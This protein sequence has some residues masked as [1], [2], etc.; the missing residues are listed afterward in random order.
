MIANRNRM[1]SQCVIGMLVVIWSGTALAQISHVE[2]R[3]LASNIIVPQSRDRAFCI[4]RREQ[5][6]QVTEVIGL[7]DI[8]DQ[9]A[10]T[11]IEIRLKNPSRRRQEAE[12]IMP[13]PEGA[14]IRGFTFQGA[15]K[16]P[17]AQVL[18]KEEAKRIYD[19]LV[20]K[21]KDPALLEFAGYNLV[22]SSV[23]PVEAN[24]TQKV[25]L[26]YEHILPIDG[27][28]IDYILPRSEMLDYKVPWKVSVKIK[29]ARPVSTIYSPSHELKEKR[30]TSNEV[31]VEIAQ[32]SCK[33]PG[34]FRLSILMQ[35]NGVTATMLSYPNPKVGGGYFL[36]LGGLPPKLAQ[37]SQDAI[38]REIILVIDRS[39]SM[40]GEK[41]EQ[42]RE[43]ALQIIA[44]LNDGEN[45]NIVIYNNTV[46][47]FS[48]KP[49]AK[50]DKYEKAAREYIKGIRAT[51]GTNI[52]DALLE[53]LRQK[54]TEGALPI[55][56]F[57]T[58]GL[59][60]VGN[61]SEVAIR[62]VAMKSNPH[63]R[64]I[65]TFGVGVDV[66]A[67]LL[68]K[69]ADETRA[70]ATFVLPKEDVE[71]KVGQVFRR[72][73]GPI[74]AYPILEIR[75]ANGEPAAGRTRDII[76]AIL[77]DLYDGDQFVLLGQYV[78][79]D[80]VT[81]LLRGNFL[82]KKKTFK[83]K[84]NF[85]KATTK[86]SF[87]PR[88]WASRKIAEL[89]DA[90]RQMG[91]DNKVAKND[92]RIKELVDEIVRL[93]TE[94]GIL[95]EYTAFLAKEGTDLSDEVAVREEAQTYMYGRA[96]RSRS[97]WGGVNQG[98]N[99][100]YQKGQ[101]TLNIS[102][103]FYDAQMNRVSIANVQQVNDLAFYRRGNRWVDSRLVNQKQQAEPQRVI[104]FGSDEFK[105]L[106]SRLAR[107]NRQGS[108]ALY[109]EVM[110]EVDGE[111]I[112][113]REK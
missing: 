17:S 48:Q 83:F 64:R 15:G 86:N 109:G 21:I 107:E 84:F 73:S 77:P 92:P 108:V 46:E 28:R 37:K 75:D 40:N 25:R 96:M 52:H 67:P 35:E 66:N 50:N 60:T 39:G 49:V 34:A 81:F 103:D 6:V 90:I 32:S 55:V 44:G 41:I 80:P 16:E 65:F 1:L 14:V 19:Q 89:I 97:G 18:P 82:G 94:F 10:V 106:A 98:L 101:S 56:L 70:K 78:G 85:K 112:L 69:I 110:L 53:T 99:L 4:V 102:N 105:Q 58:D 31:L 23:F 76:P 59:P 72:L 38:Q 45:F 7:V 74:L 3:P 47:M 113:I 68:E 63:K 51:G 54:P 91:A 24:G 43:A 9:V 79:E 87:V 33:D 111:A 30:I 62:N 22:R 36:L 5:P 12:L 8:V 11:T 42:A 26:T 13:V 95:T 61:T 100:S 2:V 104:Q 20:A 71:V 93:S 27:N 57:L 29:S 88:L